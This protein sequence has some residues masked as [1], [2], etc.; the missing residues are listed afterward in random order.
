VDLGADVNN[1][2]N[3]DN[4]LCIAVQSKNKRMVE[5][6]LEHNISNVNVREALKLSWELEEDF[7]AG[8][9]L[10]NIAMERSRD[11]VNLSGLE[12]D[13]LK[14][15]WIL[16]SLGVK[17]LPENPGHHHRRHSRQHSLGRV[18]EILSDRRKS[19]ASANPFEMEHVAYLMTDKRRRL[20]V[21]RTCLKYV[22][23][24]ETVSEVDEVD[25]GSTGAIRQS[26]KEIQE[27]NANVGT[28]PLSQDHEGE[29]HEGEGHEGEGH[30][31][32][33]LQKVN[34]PLP[35]SLHAED[36]SLKEPQ[37]V[38]VTGQP[39]EDLRGEASRK[40]SDPLLN[41]LHAEDKAQGVG[42]DLRGEASR[43]ASDPLLNSLHAEDKAQGVGQ[44][45]E[46]LRGEASW[47]ASDHA[48]D[49]GVETL[50]T[51]YRRTS[52]ESGSLSES[53]TE[54]QGSGSTIARIHRTV[55]GAATL[56]HCTLDQYNDELKSSDSSTISTSRTVQSVGNHTLSP[57]QLITKYRRPRKSTKHPFSESII[58]S[59]SF[60]SD[61]PIP[62]MYYQ[63]GD[64]HESS[65][66]DSSEPVFSP[67]PTSF[68]PNPIS[69]SFSLSPGPTSPG[70]SAFT[71][72]PALSPE[73]ASSS[74]LTFSPASTSYT[75]TTPNASTSYLSS[76]HD[77]LSSSPGSSVRDEVDFSPDKSKSHLIKM[78]DLSSN[79]LCNFHDLCAQKYGGDFVFR[80][81]REVSSFDLKQNKLTE[82][83]MPMMKVR[84]HHQSWCDL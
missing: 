69:P 1:G 72:D 63:L 6:L 37:E 21:D 48:E 25:F 47:K 3:R 32:E 12:L 52:N 81:L 30:E 34:D 28:A 9:L 60:Q 78:L 43:K 71:P 76:S 62:V 39:E 10:E 68:S 58:S 4:P 74:G 66:T 13:T 83:V 75:N 23:D 26:L 7:I 20:S 38:N 42:Q 70:P 17:T 59:L 84:I 82:L 2:E 5:C 77:Q 15:L 73:T 53:F 67:S 55:S 27:D 16:P 65:L 19:V 54:R 45:A 49:S 22:S 57:A 56:P 8:L 44:P 51:V 79:R 24:A 14:P 41:S 11:S 31:G 33:G 50:Q 29:G 64:L 80:H 61:S 35:N 40:A 46:D 36:E 18:K